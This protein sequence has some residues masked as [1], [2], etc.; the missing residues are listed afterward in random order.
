MPSR[1]HGISAAGSG[2]N[3]ACPWMGRD[4]YRTPLRTWSAGRQSR[5]A[6]CATSSRLRPT[7]GRKQSWHSRSGIAS[8]QQPAAAFA[9]VR[10][11]SREG[12]VAASIVG[13]R[14]AAFPEEP[15]T[16]LSSQSRRPSR[17]RICLPRPLSLVAIGPPSAL[18]TSLIDL[19][20]DD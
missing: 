15:R 17:L 1:S 14:S 9:P 8:N 20:L 10:L 2:R 12:A 19:G 13:R 3:S 18:A 7:V 5:S 4:R 6:A 11:G 16:A